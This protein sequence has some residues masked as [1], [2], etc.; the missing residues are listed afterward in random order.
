MAT[1]TVELYKY[2]LF[3]N[4]ANLIAY[5]RFNSGALITDSKGSYTLTNNN[6]VGETSSGKFGYAA[7]F[8]SSNTSKYLSINSNLGISGVGN[9]SVSFWVKAT[10]E[11]SS[12]KRTIFQ[13]VDNKI[14]FYCLYDYNS[15][16]RNLTF[17]RLKIGVIDNNIKT[18]ITLGTSDWYHIVLTYDGST[19][20]GYVN[21]SSVGQVSS[22]GVGSVSLSNVFVI[23]QENAQ[24]WSGLVD[25]FAVFNRVLSATEILNYYNYV[26][27]NIFYPFFYT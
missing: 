6:T 15:G 18:N 7:D 1:K 10:S 21:G 17:S 8:G 3:F 26:A 20:T 19:L 16:T 5:Y 2:P 9:L 22:S 13:L 14:M 4:D 23:G 11:I 12:G 24:Y 25:D 27:S